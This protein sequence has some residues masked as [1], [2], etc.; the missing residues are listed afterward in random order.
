MFASLVAHH[1]PGA[2]YRHR[3]GEDSLETLDAPS[4]IGLRVR[5]R[6]GPTGPPAADGT[7]IPYHLVRLPPPR[8]RGWGA[9]LIYADGGFNAPWVPQ[10]PQNGMAAI[11][12]AGGLFIHAH[13]RGGAEF[14]LEWWEGGR[15]QNKQNCYAGPLRRGRRPIARGVTTRERLAVTGGS[16]GGLMSGVAI[17]QLPGPLEGSR[18][19]GCP[20]WTSS[21]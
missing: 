10:F 13:L 3:P 12:E 21:A 6:R 15:L 7:R 18:C 4:D 9:A 1:I 20:F 11:V 16:N 8:R 17:T 19:R 14:G 5:G 2:F